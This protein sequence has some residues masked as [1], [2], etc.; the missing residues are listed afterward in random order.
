MIGRSV[1]D[2]GLR[3][4]KSLFLAEVIR[5]EQVICPV[6]PAQ[7][8]HAGDVLL[9]VGDVE[10]VGVLQEMKGLELYHEHRLRGQHLV[11]V[12]VSHSSHLIGRTIKDA[13]FRITSYNVCY[14]KLL[15]T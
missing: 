7:E 6:D 3:A 8:L 13:Q 1:K 12:I 2:N 10:S 15:R 9:F 14:T 5:G 4:L 11:E